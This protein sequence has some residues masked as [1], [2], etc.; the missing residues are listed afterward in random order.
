MVFKRQREGTCYNFA[1]YSIV[2]CLFQIFV[3]D[4]CSYWQE[5]HPGLSSRPARSIEQ[6]PALSL[7]PIFWYRQTDAYHRVFRLHHKHHIIHSH[8]QP[9]NHVSALQL[10]CPCSAKSSCG[11]AMGASIS[12]SHHERFRREGF[13]A[14]AK[15]TLAGNTIA[16][17]ERN[18]NRDPTR[19]SKLCTDMSIYLCFQTEKI[20][21]C[22]TVNL[23]PFARARTY[24]TL[25]W[26]S[27]RRPPSTFG[28]K[29]L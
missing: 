6:T 14:R 3:L 21:K 18:E 10:E 16:R 29:Q 13:K 12:P 1:N 5:R 11:R 7:P 22:D 26:R 19:K 28:N 17:Q 25:S 8:P 9:H 20:Y 2:T 4:R 23:R 15:Q 27:R 24:H